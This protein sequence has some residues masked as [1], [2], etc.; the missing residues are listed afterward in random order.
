MNTPN[1]LTT[2]RII[3]AP[4]FM[5]FLL[6]DS[7]PYNY[8]IALVFFIAASITDLIDGRLARKYKQITTYGKFLD[9]V[10]D[11]ILVLSALMGF[12]QLDI[13]SAWVPLIVVT[14]E[15]LVTAV[16]LMAS[17]QGNVI[18]ANMWGKIKTVV[19]LVAIIAIIV[20]KAFKE[21]AIGIDIP[22]MVSILSLYDKIVP[23][24]SSVLLWV[25]VVVT[26][27]SGCVYVWQNR[28]YINTTK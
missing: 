28:K 2:I 22:E 4:V 14:R 20:F 1:K 12:V 6:I 18:A 3:M 7:I 15:F 8:L 26:A 11:K 5:A 27:W 19:Q 17:T 24:V 13:C 23:T 9:P 21:I 16:R 25:S 10:A